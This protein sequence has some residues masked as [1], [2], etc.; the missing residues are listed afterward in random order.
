MVLP[1]PQASV[2]TVKFE[3]IG[4]VNL[5]LVSVADAVAVWADKAIETVTILPTLEYI[6]LEG[7]PTDAILATPVSVGVYRPLFRF[8]VVIL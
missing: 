1:E 2:K 3:A 5:N 7:V 4:K 6:L 8:P